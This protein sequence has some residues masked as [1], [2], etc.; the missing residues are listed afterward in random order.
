MS[1][2]FVH[3][4]PR[5]STPLLLPTSHLISNARSQLTTGMTSARRPMVP[6][7][8]SCRRPSTAVTARRYAA[9]TASISP[10]DLT[11]DNVRQVLADA[12]VEASRPPFRFV[13]PKQHNLRFTFVLFWFAAC[14][15]LRQ[16]SWN[17]RRSWASWIGWTICEDQSQR[18]LLAQTFHSVGQ[19]C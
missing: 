5:I 7:R 4:H 13:L 9:V 6:L 3:Y 17:N 8:W 11:E 14:A 10:L 15:D 18:S 2:E 19:S 12:R 1:R 16:F